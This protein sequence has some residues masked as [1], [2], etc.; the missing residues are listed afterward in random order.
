MQ[1][2][3]THT[4]ITARNVHYLYICVY[5][6]P[7]ECYCCCCMLPANVSLVSVN[8]VNNSNVSNSSTSERNVRINPPDGDC[9]DD[10]RPDEGSDDAPVSVTSSVLDDDDD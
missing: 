9:N 10:S 4:Y 5:I 7:N 2:T 8:F 1:Y 3:P 6:H